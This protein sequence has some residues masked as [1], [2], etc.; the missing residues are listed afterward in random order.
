MISIQINYDKCKGGECKECVDSCPVGVLTLKDNKVMINNA[1]EDC[2]FCESCMDL[3]P[4][5][6]IIVENSE[7]GI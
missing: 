4:E 1:E 2:T 5:E 7:W 6:C 3:C